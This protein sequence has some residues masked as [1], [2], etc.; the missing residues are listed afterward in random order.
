MTA[1]FAYPPRGMSREEAARYIGVSPSLFD[2]MV[3]DG[4]MPKPRRANARV[5]WDRVSLDAAFTDLPT[6][7]NAIDE[8]LGRTKLK[9]V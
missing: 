4:R 5:I 9:V 6:K 7:G 3:G 2:E 8:A 1:A